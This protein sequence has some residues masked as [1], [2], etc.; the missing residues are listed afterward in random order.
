[1]MKTLIGIKTGKDNW[2]IVVH[3]KTMLTSKMIGLYATMKIFQNDLNI[4]SM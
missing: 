2:F 1:M 3:F 4:T